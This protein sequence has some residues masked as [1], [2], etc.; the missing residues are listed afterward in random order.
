MWSSL[1]VEWDGRITEGEDDD[2]G[3]SVASRSS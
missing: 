1:L 3:E 2:E